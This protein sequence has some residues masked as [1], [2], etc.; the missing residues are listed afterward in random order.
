[1]TFIV[2]NDPLCP[3]NIVWLHL[4]QIQH[5]NSKVHTTTDQRPQT[6]CVHRILVGSLQL[7]CPW[8]HSIV[9]LVSWDYWYDLWHDSPQS[10]GLCRFWDE[11]TWTKRQSTTSLSMTEQR[12]MFTSATA[13]FSSVLWCWTPVTN[14]W[15]HVHRILIWNWVILLPNTIRSSC[16]RSDMSFSHESPY[17]SRIGASPESPFLA[18]RSLGSTRF[19]YTGLYGG[20][21]TPKDRDDVQRRELWECEGWE[22]DL[23]AIGA[24]SIYKSKHNAEALT[25]ICPTLDLRCEENT[26]RR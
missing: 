5:L 3:C 13:L 20:R 23:E 9:H 17:R 10:S 6:K 15:T 24:P 25:R 8:R 7:S 1:M 21:G 2:K 16:T 12:C 4:S 18:R 14:P 11:T 19:A 22:C 26:V